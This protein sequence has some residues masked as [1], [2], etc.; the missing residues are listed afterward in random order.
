[1][2]FDV[3]GKP[4]YA[5]TGGRPFD[6]ALPLVVFIHGASHDHS[7]W[8]L[9]SRYLAHHGHAVLA[10]DLPGHGRSAGPALTTV[11][12]QAAWVLRAIAAARGCADVSGDA[13]DAA[14]TADVGEAADRAAAGPPIHLVGH[15]MGSLIALEASGQADPGAGLAGI[16]LVGTAVPM[17]VSDALLATADE[18][19]A[20]AFDMINFWSHSGL[21][22]PPGAPGP[23]FSIFNQNRRLMER[24][25]SGVLAV[26]FRACND[27]ADGLARA[28][29]C[30]VPALLVLGALDQM[31][32]VR[33]TR[34]L[35]AA[36]PRSHTVVVPAA[37]HALMS[38]QP[39]RTLVAIRDWLDR[40]P[41]VPAR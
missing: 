19:E 7:V 41:A 13:S 8:V 4:A 20:K 34:D 39:E 14:A 1:M 12:D 29:Q 5:Y 16:V 10:L 25:A 28:R 11:A 24:Q 2:K 6:P 15:S 30:P 33:A 37:G 27:Y 31:T 23:G 9:Q 32:P 36:L 40:L 26:D 17:K 3:D 38:E 18:D 22:H 21:T 35:V